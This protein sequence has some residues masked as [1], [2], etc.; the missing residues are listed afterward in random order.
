MQE[1]IPHDA[2]SSDSRNLAVLIYILTI[3]CPLLPG[4][5][6]FIA[7]KDDRFVLSAAR[8]TLNWS[9][10]FLLGSAAISV[11]NGVLLFIPILGWLLMGI[12]W[13]AVGAYYLLGVVGCVLGAMNASKGLE[14]RFP[15]IVR[16]IS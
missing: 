2:P 6:G 4:L 13:L 9:I 7:K 14:H 10:C 8:E 11:L 16:L 1:Y 3:F 5:V 12:L 15:F